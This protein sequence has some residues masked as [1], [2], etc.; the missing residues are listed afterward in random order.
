MQIDFAL[1]RNRDQVLVT[2]AKVVP[3]ETVTTQHR[4]LICTMKITP[5]MFKQV[6]QSGPLRNKWWKLKEKEAA[7]TSRIRLPTVVTVGK[8][9]TLKL[10]RPKMAAGA[11]TVQ[12]AIEL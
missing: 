6:E 12:L 3:Y 9:Q 11:K 2:D 4:P 7:V 8:L 5:P 10:R 1:V